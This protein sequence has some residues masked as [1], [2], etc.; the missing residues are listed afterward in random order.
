M[1]DTC[2]LLL[3]EAALW[4]AAH[5]LGKLH[6]GGGMAP[7]DSLFGFK[8]QFNKN[9]RREFWVGR[10]IFDPAAYQ[11]LLALRKSADPA[12]DPDNGFMIQ[13]RR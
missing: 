8:K 1:G 5:G 9:G 12:F 6:L 7:D 2:E 10:G 11:E 3:Y 4:G 13:Y